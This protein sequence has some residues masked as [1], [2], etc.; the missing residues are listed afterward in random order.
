MI[1]RHL[2]LYYLLVSSSSFTFEKLGT[3]G[4]HQQTPLDVVHVSYTIRTPKRLSF[5]AVVE[6]ESKKTNKQTS[7]HADFSFIADFTPKKIYKKVKK[8]LARPDQRA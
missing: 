8:I 4:F 1:R 5:V 7:I 2:D 6:M 3:L